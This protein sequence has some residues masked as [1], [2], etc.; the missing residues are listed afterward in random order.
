MR[1]RVTKFGESVLSQKAQEVK[2][3]DADLEKLAGDM[4]ETMHGENGLGLAAPQVGVS[5]RVFVIDMRRR[6]DESRECN[7]TLDG[8][9]IPL[10]L[11]MPL[12]A[13]N[14]KIENTGEYFE[15]AEEGCLSFP[16]IYGEVERCYAVKLKYFDLKGAMHELVCDALFARCVQHEYDHLNGITFT[17][18]MQPKNIAKILPKLKKLKRQT[19]DF[20][21]NRQE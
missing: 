3:F 2:K 12:V 5:A 13:V 10:E 7:F 17:D 6:A 20:L 21:K 9:V 1:H 8:R 16:G 4:I 15:T 11:A 18:R 19:R 14:P